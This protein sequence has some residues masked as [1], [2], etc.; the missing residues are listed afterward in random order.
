ME[1]LN[2]LVDFC[3][4]G[5]SHEQLSVAGSG[6]KW[7]SKNNRSDLRFTRDLFKDAIKYLMNSC[8]FTFGGKLLRQVIGIPMGSDPAP[9]M[10]NLFLYY[11]ENKWV[12]NLKKENLMKARKFSHTFRFIDDLIA[13]NDND[14]FLHSFKEIY[15]EELQLNLENSGEHVTFLDLDLIK[16]DRQLDMKL[17]DK[18]DDFPFSIV[19]LPFASSNIPTSMFYTS[20]GAEILRIGRLSSSVENFVSSS[21]I[22]LKRVRFK[23]LK[24]LN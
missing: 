14:Q 13:I 19:R 16:N 15:P 21:R 6:A 5:G 9:I 12:R 1:V 17:F 23:V 8:Y 4:Q 20:V 3:F 18:R 7:V 11:Y 10:A 2:E 24:Y 22:L